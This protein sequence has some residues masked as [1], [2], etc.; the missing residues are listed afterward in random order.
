MLDLF[1]ARYA[2]VNLRR[3]RINHDLG[4]KKGVKYLTLWAVNVFACKALTTVLSFPQTGPNCA[5][6]TSRSR[7]VHISM[8]TIATASSCS[9]RTSIRSRSMLVVVIV[10]PWFILHKKP[11]VVTDG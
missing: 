2:V 10:D 8:A 11:C 3:T 5:V 4:T 6:R 1:H 9:P 7:G